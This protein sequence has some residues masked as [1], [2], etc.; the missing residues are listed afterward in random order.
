MYRIKNQSFIR[1]CTGI[2]KIK[3]GLNR[4]NLNR[5]MKRNMDK[6]ISILNIEQFF[7]PKYS[8]DKYMRSDGKLLKE[9]YVESNIIENMKLYGIKYEKEVKIE[10]GRIDIVIIKQTFDN[11]KNIYGLYDMIHG[12]TSELN[13]ALEKSEAIKI[14]KLN[15]IK[16][17]RVEECKEYGGYVIEIKN[18]KFW[19]NGIGQLQSYTSNKRYKGYKKI[20]WLFNDKKDSISDTSKIIKTIKNTCNSNDIILRYCSI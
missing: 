13:K 16:Y 11:E 15:E 3:F 9:L 14:N 10:E 5:G 4:I 7:K 6:N 20:L 17:D 1:Y 19:K 2:N 12:K 18:I 8:Y